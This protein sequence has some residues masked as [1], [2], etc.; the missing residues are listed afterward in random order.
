M[1]NTGIKYKSA[2]IRSIPARLRQSGE[3]FYPC[4]YNIIAILLLSLLSPFTTAQI[5]AMTEQRTI[6][7]LFN[8]LPDAQGT[9][10]VDVLN[11]LSM[12]LAPR[13]FDSGYQY[14]SEALALSDELNYPWGKGMAAFNFGNC[15]YFKPDLKNALSNY[16][17]ALRL[18][19]P[20]EPA[21]EIGDLFYQ[22]GTLNMHVYNREKVFDCFQR[23]ASNYF[24]VGD[25]V[26]AMV[27]YYSIADSYLYIGQALEQLDDLDS[28][29][30]NMMMDSAIR[31]MNVVLDYYLIPHSRYTW[32]PAEVYLTSIYNIL[33]VFYMN[34][35]DESNGIHYYLKGLETSRMIKDSTYRDFFQGLMC[36]NVGGAYYSPDNPDT[37]YEYIYQALALLKKTDRYDIYS[38]TLFE[39]GE[40]EMNQVH[41]HTSEQHFIEALNA[42]D[43]F[44]LKAG[45]IH[46]HDPAFRLW[47]V[48]QMHSFRIQI[49][50]SLVHLYEL[51]GDYKKAFENQK[52][53]EEEK[54]I[55]SLDELR[56]EMIGLQ[57]NYEDELKRQEIALLVSDNELNRLK[58]I[59]NRILFGSIGSLGLITLLL[60]L[61]INQR[62]RFRLKRKAL[63]LEQKLLRAQMNPHF[64]FNSLYSIQN[65]I[66]TEKPDKASIYLSKF[67]KLVRNILDNSTEEFVPLEKEI[68]TIENYLELQQVRYVGKFSYRI[69]ID[70]EIDPEIM[71]IPPMLAQPFIENAIEHGIKHRETPGHIDIRFSLKDHT[72]L[73]EVED[74][75]VGRQRAREIEIVQDPGHRSMATSLTRERLANLN[76]K[77]NKKIML[78]IIDLKNALGEATGTRVVFGVPME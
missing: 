56:R 44:L 62:K 15:Y 78:E 42:S 3:R 47:A 26:A 33:G 36:S 71:Q 59:R 10:K 63:L 75:G 29:E 65:F 35:G 31:Y 50:K 1:L 54:S 64:I 22:L 74:D 21:R 76:R 48:T 67:A 58:L 37:A 49:L 7:S 30:M 73:F 17:D 55:Q 9:G 28:G 41:F 46:G 13:S 5:P 45:Q 40:M 4:A 68:S 19:E 77:L 43:T 32:L 25:T 51:T 57:A 23:A 6:D 72:L 38:N 69:D 11:Q 53:L 27:M 12:N 24:E 20:F 8:L 60:F 61:L 70:D 18:L 16:L 66:V 39:L 14:T 34:K 2:F 52:R